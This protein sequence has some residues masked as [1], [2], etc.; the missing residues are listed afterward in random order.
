M[1]I[2]DIKF[3]K[4]IEN[5]ICSTT[6]GF[7]IYE[8]DPELKK[9]VGQS[10]N[11]SI[12]KSYLLETT[13]IIILV[14]GGKDPYIPP[15]SIAVWDQNKKKNAKI[16][17]IGRPVRNAFITKNDY[18]GI[19]ENKII[20]VCDKDILI[21]DSKSNKP[22]DIKSTYS[23]P[24]GLC[25]L[26]YSGDSADK[27]TIVTLGVTKGKISTW[28][29]QTN[30]YKEIAAHAENIVALKL[31]HDGTLVATASENGTNIHV[32]DIATG[33]LKY[34]LRRGTDIIGS[35]KIYDIC[36]RY[37]NKYLA[38][39]S[40]NGTIHIFDLNSDKNTNANQKS[41]LY[42]GSDYL[43]KYFESEWSFQRHSIGSN[44]K[45][46]CEF[47]KKN[48]LHVLTY[49]GDYYKVDDKDYKTLKRNTLCA[50]NI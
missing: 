16:I 28:I 34:K 36:F 12:G 14:G 18:N 11:K 8:L 39:C 19:T 31:S 22:I 5:I 9:I 45:M 23:N 38:C 20:V 33:K 50:N 48:V 13:N 2:L 6:H 7:L 46:I 25:S 27:M 30:Q 15:C 26:V 3:N 35:T 42:W 1:S 24:N 4:N 47:D 41:V 17:N 43:P 40:S 37:D 29:L 49:E 21:F 10:F 32:Y 44:C